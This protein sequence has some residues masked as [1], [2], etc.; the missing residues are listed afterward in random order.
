MCECMFVRTLADVYYKHVLPARVVRAC[1]MET[2]GWVERAQAT[3]QR[4]IAGCCA[5]VCVCA[6]NNW[7]FMMRLLS[8]RGDVTDLSC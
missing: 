3:K 8:V 7:T 5:C 2:V 1:P 4:S 6:E